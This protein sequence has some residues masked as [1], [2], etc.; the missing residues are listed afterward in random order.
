[1]IFTLGAGKIDY[2]KVLDVNKLIVPFKRKKKYKIF[3]A[4]Y[5]GSTRLID[6]I[7]A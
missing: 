6:N 4:Y 3:I 2:I 5:L 7:E 1:M